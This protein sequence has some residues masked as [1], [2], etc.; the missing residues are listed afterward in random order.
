MK[1]V[2]WPAEIN[3]ISD[4]VLVT[5]TINSVTAHVSAVYEQRVSARHRQCGAEPTTA[6]NQVT[7]RY[8]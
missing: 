5:G 2:R 3:P 6:C 1:T 7:A 4:Q 8:L